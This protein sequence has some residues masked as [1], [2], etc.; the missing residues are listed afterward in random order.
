MQAVFVTSQSQE[1]QDSATC[2][3]RYKTRLHNM[4]VLAKDELLY[5]EENI[6]KLPK[7]PYEL[8]DYKAVEFIQLVRASLG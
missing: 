3:H 8:V 2:V 7:D 4:L 6:D 5:A 1:I